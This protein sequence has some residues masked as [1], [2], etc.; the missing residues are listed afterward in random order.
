[1]A[2]KQGLT[3][4]ISQASED[5]RRAVLSRAPNAIKS[6][7][8][9][10]NLNTTCTIKSAPPR[11][12]EVMALLSNKSGWLVKRNEQQVWQRRWCCVVPHTFLYYFEAEPAQ[13]EGE[14]DDGTREGFSG[15][16][17]Y[18]SSL[19]VENQ[20]QLNDAVRDGCK[21]RDG[22]DS[23]P[24]KGRDANTMYSPPSGEK[25]IPARVRGPTT[26]SGNLS[27]A[28]IIDLE[29]YSVVN[30]SSRNEL[31]FELTG[32]EITNPDLRSFYFQAGSI[33]D[34]EMWTNALLSDRHSALKDEREAYRQVCESFQLQLQNLSDMIDEAEGKTSQAETQLYN[35][36]SG[37]EKFR[38]QVVSIVREAL[39]QKCWIA[40]KN[41][42]KEAESNIEKLVQHLEKSRLFFLDQI[43]EVI[44]C[45]NLGTAKNT[46]A[47]IT[48]IL[49]DYLTTVVGSYTEI[50]VIVKSMEHK[51]SRSAGVDKAAV[52]DM[53]LKLERVE[54]EK[55]EE[56]NQYKAKIATMTAQMEELQKANEEME[57]QMKTQRVEFSMFQSQAKSKLKELSQHKKILKKEVIEL[58]K[59]NDEVGSER[60]A[61]F[62]ITD[63]H[64]VQ[65]ETEK[66]KNIMLE[67]YIEKMENQVAVQQNMMEMISLSGMSQIEDGAGGAAS[68]SNSVVGRIIGAPDDGS[69]SSFGPR[70]YRTLPL[71]DHI[72]VRDASPYRLPPR[73]RIP[74]ENP[75]QSPVRR[76]PPLSM[77]PPASP[78]AIQT[79]N[80]EDYNV[81][82]E[83]NNMS[84]RTPR[85][86]TLDHEFMGNDAEKKNGVSPANNSEQ[87]NF[88]HEERVTRYQEALNTQNKLNATKQKIKHDM[89]NNLEHDDDD[90]DDEDDRS[91]ISELTEDRTQRAYDSKLH[92]ERQ[93]AIQ[94]TMSDMTGENVLNGV[95]EKNLLLTQSKDKDNYPPRFILGSSQ[96]N[97][98]NDP[99]A[100]APVPVPQSTNDQRDDNVMSKNISSGSSVTG[101]KLSVAQRAR[102]AAEQNPNKVNVTAEADTIRIQE[103]QER[104]QSIRPP[105]K[106]RSQSP[107][108]FSSLASMIGKKT[109]ARS[110][111]SD[112]SSNINGQRGEV[113]LTLAERQQLQ[114]ERQLRVLREQGL[115]R[116]GEGSI[117]G[118]PGAQ[119]I[120]SHSTQKS[121]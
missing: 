60:D 53:R 49:A 39:D 54:A 43:D 88:T 110:H 11:T 14:D 105:P 25:L 96:G 20:D 106:T 24:L 113:T 36:R 86:G 21:G 84:E 80:S 33:E 65:V 62:H 61:A 7:T 13:E 74:T 104:T 26:T 6:H 120:R 75:P 119:S 44:S 101:T 8:W 35:V 76:K 57:N 87:S 10:S 89:N 15:G 2:A 102:L 37:A 55:D 112:S 93:A 82:S 85:R 73:S 108:M 40:D 63:G 41:M 111:C 30:R 50:G 66:E 90:D 29:C 12:P 64:K 67:K 34:C 58:R 94:Y 51:L 28:G 23:T 47:L 71:R 45:E 3:A 38:S 4:H 117:T 72:N 70:H 17:V 92:Q 16:G 52:T 79:N 109:D 107:G 46:G 115:L 59:K 27:P 97:G 103:A 83:K 116:G 91:H 78:K 99:S 95:P 9:L 114:K 5:A 68:R 100:P 56:T 48:Q 1:M 69:L 22:R 42:D 18:T 81:E 31:V 19:V 32:D 118:G 77:V 98:T 121:R